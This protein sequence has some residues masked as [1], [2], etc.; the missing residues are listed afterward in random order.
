MNIKTNKPKHTN[1]NTNLALSSIENFLRKILFYDRSGKSGEEGPR[2][3]INFYYKWGVVNWDR[4][5]LKRKSQAKIRSVILDMIQGDDKEAIDASLWTD[6]QTDIVETRLRNKLNDAKIKIKDLERKLNDK[7]ELLYILAGN[8]GLRALYKA[9]ETAFTYG[10][11]SAQYSKIGSVRGA[12]VYIVFE[13]KRLFTDPDGYWFN[14][15]Y[16]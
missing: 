14:D 7:G 9:R 10:K 13:Y 8:D 5:N 1:R 16:K 15:K 3:L 6:I 11:D 4:L 12:G 2:E